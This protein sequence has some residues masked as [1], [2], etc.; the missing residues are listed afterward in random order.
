MY[1]TA[2][3]PSTTTLG[4]SIPMHSTHIHVTAVHVHVQDK[5]GTVLKANH[6]NTQG[7]L[8]TPMGLKLL[9]RAGEPLAH[10]LV[11]RVGGE[12]LQ[13]LAVGSV[14]VCVLYQTRDNYDQ[15]QYER[16]GC[17]ADSQIVCQPPDPF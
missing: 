8:A 9:Y 4:S 7:T 1:S 3:R 6:P 10:G 14:E 13:E 16:G 15:Q 5:L 2:N 12:H 11:C 17:H